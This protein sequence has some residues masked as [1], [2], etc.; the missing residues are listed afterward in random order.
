[1]LS[2]ILGVLLAAIS[3]DG[4]TGRE[5]AAQASLDALNVRI[6][7]PLTLTVDFYGTADFASI[8]PPELS[9]YV[10]AKVWK[11]DDAS[12]KTE[13]YRNA[14]RLVYRV[15][16]RK[17]GLVEFPSLSFSYD[18]ADGGAKAE[19]STE[20]IP[21]H[22]KPGSQVALAELD[23][24]KTDRPLPDGL[25][26][27][28]SASPWGSA[29]GLSEDRLFAWRKACS[30]PS[31]EAFAPFDFPEARLNEAA[32]EILAGNWARAI[33]I[34]SR[35]EWSIGQTTAIER[36][37][38]A[39]TALKTGDAN[40]ELQ[41]WRQVLRPVL[42]HSAP[43][44]IGIVLGVLL[45]AVVAILLVRK[46]VRALAAL[47]VILAATTAFAA[48]ERRRSA[49]VDPFAEMERLRRQMAEQM[50]AAFGQGAVAP[51]GLFNGGGFFGGGMMI[52]GQ[53][54]PEVKV[55]ASVRPDKTGLAAGEPFKFILALEMPK[56][57]TVSDL[58]FAP[59][60]DFGYSIVGDGEALTDGRA[61]NTNN[62]VKR[63]AI[64][65]RY[66]A[67]FSGRV[68]FTVAGQYTTRIVQNGGR[69]TSTYSSTFSTES[70]PIWMEVR[71]LS[72]KNRPADYT[73]AVGTSF[74]LKQLVDTRNVATND[75]V[76]VVCRLD[77]EGFLPPG[78]IPGGIAEEPG[79]VAFKRYFVADGSPT[80]KPLE[81]PY[82][83]VNAKDYRRATCPGLKLHY[84]PDADETP[85]TV[86]VNAGEEARE[87]GLLRLHFAPR[88][89]SP[90]IGTADPH[91]A[92]LTVTETHGSWSRI[93]DGRH[94]GWVLSE[95]LKK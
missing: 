38:I 30:A 53:P 65:V 7:D 26:V 46:G 63:I 80:T 88:A 86:V 34:Y 78:A 18:T 31:P 24:V 76:T 48:G 66:D 4:V 77:Y 37:L 14:R 11:V 36:G 68:T 27:D 58:Q 19:V 59:S 69:F 29:E 3:L 41:M 79:V 45:V 56:A 92:S 20:A 49:V 32:C 81:F 85:K 15:R 40:A 62:V 64:P 93:D 61:S 8:H 51:G 28:L 44:R 43:G 35:L 13:T 17:V 71:P 84:V 25:L 5:L 83:D 12:A 23:V 2:S 82:Y 39:A 54:A 89:S 22:V 95:D 87:N 73:G 90:E 70:A 94:A 75:V 9:R 21:V 10:D 55:T 57:C 1:M 33:K 60:Q 6:G 50:D 67:P 72:D 52:N 16:P 47:A 74:R 42:R 91:S